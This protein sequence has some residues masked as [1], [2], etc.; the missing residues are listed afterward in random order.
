VRNGGEGNWLRIASSGGFGS[1][2]VTRQLL[3]RVCIH[4][5][6]FSS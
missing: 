2:H 6:I 1:G 3:A 4:I 5:C